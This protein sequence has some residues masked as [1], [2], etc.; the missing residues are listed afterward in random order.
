MN[1]SRRRSHPDS[2]QTCVGR[3]SGI[4]GRTLGAV[5]RQG[6]VHLGTDAELLGSIFCRVRLDSSDTK[7]H[8][9]PTASGFSDLA[10]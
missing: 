4:D 1:P 5:H 3:T 7:L 2:Q 10:H 9:E 8:S 6:V